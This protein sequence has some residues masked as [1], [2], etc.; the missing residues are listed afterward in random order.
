MTV[1]CGTAYKSIS[2]CDCQVGEWGG[3]SGQETWDAPW[4]CSAAP[5]LPPDGHSTMQFH[6]FACECFGESAA[7]CNLDSPP[8]LV[9]V[10]G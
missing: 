1:T 3:P 9:Q 10:V 8:A 5:S 4:V 2:I 6:C 7:P